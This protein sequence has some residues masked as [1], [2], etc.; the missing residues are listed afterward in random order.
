MYKVTEKALNRVGKS[1]DVIVPVSFFNR[2]RK[3]VKRVL[4]KRKAF[5]MDLLYV[6]YDGLDLFVTEGK[7]DSFVML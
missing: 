5:G 6:N 1:V 4:H 3:T 2:K 7:N